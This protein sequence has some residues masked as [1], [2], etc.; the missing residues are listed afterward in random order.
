MK[1]YIA[2][3]AM[4]ALLLS[5]CAS[6]DVVEQTEETSQEVGQS[7]SE[8]EESQPEGPQE[9]QLVIP[10]G[11][12]LARVGMTLEEM[13][14][15]TAEEFIRETQNGD[16]S[17]YPL[18]AAQTPDENRCFLLEGYLFPDTYSIYSTETPNAVIGKLLSNT[19][20]RITPELR[21]RI[22]TG[23]YTVDEIL[24]LA[25][26]IEK[27]ALGGYHM[28][29]ISSVLHNRLDAGMQLQCDVTIVYVEGAVKPFIDGDINRYNEYYNTYKCP[30]L[31]AGA[32]CNPGLAAIEAALSPA[33]TDYY[34]F[35]TDEDRNYYYASTWEEHEENLV[36][37][38]LTVEE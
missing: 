13:G 37:A 24:T 19:E 3:A 14:I 23:G 22:D 2:M 34:Y 4:A 25:S 26:I 17:S 32:I 33:D 30:A 27:E 15:C 36:A 29:M 7:Q 18:V 10:E 31:P 6:R 12:T 35:V 5:G 16:F 9:M 8:P 1:R 38:G 28:P 20:T 21:A 11:Y